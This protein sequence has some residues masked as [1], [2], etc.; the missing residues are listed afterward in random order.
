MFGIFDIKINF[1]LIFLFI[2]LN[3]K[4]LDRIIFAFKAGVGYMLTLVSKK[5]FSFVFSIFW[6]AINRCKTKILFGESNSPY[7]N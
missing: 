5:I 2:N 4:I 1:V 6:L 7:P 3:S